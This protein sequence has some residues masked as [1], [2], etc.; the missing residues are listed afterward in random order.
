MEAA[1]LIDARRYEE[2]PPRYQYQLTDKGR[3]LHVVLQDLCTWANQWI[4]GTWVPPEKFM[5]RGAG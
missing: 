5:Q 1:G 3:A 4:P 2:R